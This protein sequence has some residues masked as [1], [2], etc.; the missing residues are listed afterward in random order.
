MAK[1]KRKELTEEQAAQRAGELRS[2]IRHHDQLYYVHDAPEVSDEEYDR[3]FRELK[4]IEERFPALRTPDSP[5]QRVSGKPLDQFPTIVHAAPM[6][7]LDSS[8]DEG[9]LRR[10]DERVRKALDDTPVRYTLEPNLDG[11]TVE[12]VY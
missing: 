1:A 2:R 10:F 9:P 6:L 5:T 11:A 4:E 12:L 7:S 3:L 8:A